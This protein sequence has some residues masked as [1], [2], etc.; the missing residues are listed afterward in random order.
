[1][2]IQLQNF[3]YFDQIQAIIQTFKTFNAAFGDKEQLKE[4]FFKPIYNFD[5]LREELDEMRVRLL[6]DSHKYGDFNESEIR[7]IIDK[8]NSNLTETR[9][10]KFVLKFLLTNCLVKYGNLID[11]FF[12][13][14]S[15][16]QCDT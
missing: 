2:K 7:V 14:T 16:R 4:V 13:C 5:T 12:K 3:N 11:P 6:N 8:M 15:H 10:N 1:M 9:T